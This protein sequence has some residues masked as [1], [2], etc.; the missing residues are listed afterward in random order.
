MGV[1]D[2]FVRQECVEHDL[3]RR[4]GRRRIDQACALDADKLVVADLAE[5]A[6]LAQWR[7]PHRREA[8]E[9]DHCHVGASRLDAKHLDVGAKAVAHHFFQRG[10]AAAVQDKFRVTAEQ[11]RRV[12]A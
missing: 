12:D 10:V 5:R 9:I 2:E 4:I 1:I 11:S 7:K 3:H 6:Q 8:C